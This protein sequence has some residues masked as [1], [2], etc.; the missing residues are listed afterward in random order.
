MCLN[1][2]WQSRRLLSICSCNC[3]GGITGCIQ[4]C[5]YYPLSISLNLSISPVYITLNLSSPL[6]LFT[7]LPPPIYVSSNSPCIYLYPQVFIDLYLSPSHYLSISLRLPIYLRPPI[8]LSPSTYL[9]IS[10]HLSIYLPPSIYSCL[11][12]TT[13]LLPSI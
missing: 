1:C 6:Y 8:Y 3:E 5:L 9:S 2:Y 10:L 13:Y 4:Q 7:Y 12:L 11:H